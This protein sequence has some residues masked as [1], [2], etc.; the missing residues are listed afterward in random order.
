MCFLVTLLG[1]PLKGQG[2]KMPPK[3]CNS[4]HHLPT[5]LKGVA[6]SN[7][8]EARKNVLDHWTSLNKLFEE[9]SVSNGVRF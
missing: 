5:H 1:I 9:K 4:P 2:T 3:D 6:F 7:D 8:V